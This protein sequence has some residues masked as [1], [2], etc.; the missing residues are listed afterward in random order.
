MSDGQEI[1]KTDVVRSR[2]DIL[3]KIEKYKRS[4]VLIAKERIPWQEMVENARSAPSPKPFMEAIRVHIEAGRPALIAEVKKASPSKG[5]IRS[6]FH[7]AQLGLAYLVGGATCLS[8]LTDGP[9]FQGSPDYLR[10]ARSASGLPTLCKDFLFDPYQVLQARTWGADCIL[11][12]MACVTDREAEQLVATAREVGMDV[13]IE[14]HNRS[15]LDR[16]LTIDKALIGINNRDLHTFEVSLSVTEELAPL[17][18]AD[19]VVISE[20]GI[21]GHQDVIRLMKAGV[22]AFLVGESL[23]RQADVRCATHSLLFG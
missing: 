9:S 7:P 6:D 5:I 22:R 18:P 2:P 21:A 8:V 1:A 23:M 3:S 14:V 20:S 12:I 4:E 17:I 13:L 16:A 11:V 19:R 15:E 10:I